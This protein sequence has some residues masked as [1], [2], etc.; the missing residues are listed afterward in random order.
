MMRRVLRPL[1][2]LT[3]RAL[4]PALRRALAL[5]VLCA[6]SALAGDA[7]DDFASRFWVPTDEL[8]LRLTAGHNELW[9]AISESF[10][11]WGVLGWLEPTE[12]VTVVDDAG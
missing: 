3:R 5:T 9:L 11:G 2:P 8:P 7:A 12:G 6:A 4:A 10:G 1:P